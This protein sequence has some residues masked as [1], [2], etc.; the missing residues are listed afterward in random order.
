M[1]KSL[2]TLSHIVSTT[3]TTGDV[4]PCSSKSR[5][6][7]RYTRKELEI[8]A[9]AKGVPSISLKTMDELCKELGIHAMKTKPGGSD[10]GATT[11]TMDTTT[12]VTLV[13]VVVAPPPRPCGTGLRTKGRYTRAELVALAKQKGIKGIS[14]KKISD[15]CIELGLVDVAPLSGG[16]SVAV[17]F[18]TQQSQAQKKQCLMEY[19]R[20]CNSMSI[21]S[22]RYKLSEL[23]TFWNTR[24]AHLSEFKN[25]SKA[26]TRMNEYCALLRKRYERLVLQPVLSGL[27]ATLRMRLERW[28]KDAKNRRR[29]FITNNVKRHP[30]FHGCLHLTSS[31][32][33][34]KHVFE[35]LETSKTTARRK[36]GYFTKIGLIGFVPFDEKEARRQPGYLYNKNYFVFDQGFLDAQTNYVLG[37]TMHDKY[38]ALTYTYGGDKIVNSFLLGQFRVDNM[39]ASTSNYETQFLFPLALDLWLSIRETTSLATFLDRF[40]PSQIK[41]TD[42]EANY[43]VSF[44]DSVFSLTAEFDFKTYSTLLEFVSVYGRQIRPEHW[45]HLVARYIRHLTRIIQQ[46][47]PVPASGLMVYRG[48]KHAGFVNTSPGS[49]VFTNVTFMSTSIDLTKAMQSSFVNNTT[50]CCVFVIQLLPKSRCLFLGPMSYYNE[51]EILLAPNA[52]LFMTRSLQKSYNSDYH[53]IH[54]ALVN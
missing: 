12:P 18:P 46:A 17:T 38:R 13:P 44:F 10:G 48:V 30:Y 39:L 23:R 41:W 29:L 49:N 45:N 28:F 8:L 50:K 4:R 51:A 34:N 24:C 9:R 16:P 5:H 26:P 40:F 22:N 43:V 31:T 20:P 21:E 27:S 14:F 1:V 19:N 33:R 37:L 42:A 15:L 11:T 52:R 47:P 2:K 6:R 32:N 3:G 36:V 35:T 7:F 53:T 54:F 25:L